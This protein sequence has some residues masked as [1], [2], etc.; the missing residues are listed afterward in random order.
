MKKIIVFASVV[1]PIFCACN[2]G[3]TEIF[4]PNPPR[5]DETPLA[6]YIGVNASTLS[7]VA[8]TAQQKET[9]YAFQ[10]LKKGVIFSLGVRMPQTNESYKVTL[11][12]ADAMTVIKQK[13]I[14][15]DTAIAAYRFISLNSNG[16]NDEVDVVPGKKYIISVNAAAIT[17]GQPNRQW[18]QLSKSNSSDF[19]PLTQGNIKILEGRYTANAAPVPTFPE[20]TNF[21]VFGLHLL[22]GLVDIGYY[23][24]EY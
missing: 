19:L 9:G 17:P 2:K 20:K 18:Y 21:D 23:K 13:T 1:I 14:S 22:F 7:I 10:V 15:Y 16:I 4:N 12:D 11:W 8:N 3:Q 5:V 6:T 24:T